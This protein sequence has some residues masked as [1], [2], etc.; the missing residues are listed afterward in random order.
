[1]KLAHRKS[2]LAVLALFGVL[3]AATPFCLAGDGIDSCCNACSGHWA[4]SSVCRCCDR[5]SCYCDRICQFRVVDGCTKCA[6]S[7]TW[8]APNALAT[9]LREYYIP[10]PPQCCWY[11]GYATGHGCT[12]A[13]WETPADTNCQHVTILTSPEVS[14][15]AAIGFSPPQFE[16]LGKVHNE[17]DVVGP[18]GSPGNNGA[19]AP[20]RR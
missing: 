7:R 11:G 13:T 8:H 6:W 19:A 16:R 3:G 18:M 17:L 1:M 12:G 2:I 9:P 14:P 4:N 5:C 15:E 20:A 10:R